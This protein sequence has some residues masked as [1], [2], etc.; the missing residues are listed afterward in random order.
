MTADGAASGPRVDPRYGLTPEQALERMQA[1]QGL[2]LDLAVAR[3]G[4]EVCA[5]LARHALS[6]IHI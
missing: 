6:L 1:L 4:Q 2:A 5:V 3:T